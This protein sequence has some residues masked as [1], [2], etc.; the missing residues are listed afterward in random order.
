MAIVNQIVPPLS[1][2]QRLVERNRTGSPSG[3]PLF[4]RATESTPHV[5]RPPSGTNRR[6][7]PSRRVEPRSQGASEETAHAPTNQQ[8]RE[9]SWTAPPRSRPPSRKKASAMSATPRLGTPASGLE[10][11]SA[12]TTRTASASPM[13]PSSDASNQS[14]SRRPTSPCGSA[15]RRTA[16]SRQPG[17]MRGVASGML[18]PKW[19]ELRDENKY[20][21]IVLF[22]R[23]AARIQGA[24]RRRH[25]ARRT[26]PRE[27]AGHDRSLLEKN[28]GLCNAEY[29]EKNKSSGLAA[30]RRKHVAVGRAVL[31]LDFTGKS[32]NMELASRTSG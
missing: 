12:F 9:R 26:A 23:R 28:V 5:H 10:L 8:R 17:S 2:A 6:L 15:R 32:G 4:W 21:H 16:T 14:A 31:R 24:G 1:T 20:E 22:A 19:R 30:M 13:P 7:H 25:E 3:V 18:H 11:L 27:G 29:A